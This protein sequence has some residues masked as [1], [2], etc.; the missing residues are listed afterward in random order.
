MS[1]H[2]PP[3]ADPRPRPRLCLFG[4]TFDPVHL[5]HLAIACAAK[6]ALA[7]DEVRFLPCRI[8]PHKLDRRSA[9]AVDR[10]TMLHL[11]T[12]GLPWAVVDPLELEQPGPSYSWQTATT[13]RTQHPQARLFWLVGGD[14]WRE[15]PTWARPDLLAATLE[16]IVVARDGVIE[17]RPGW[18]SHALPATHPASASAIRASAAAG[19]LRTDWLD[20]AVADYLAEHQLYCADQGS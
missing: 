11:A 12:R 5:G 10:V 20:P 4:G 15:L 6:S 3:A 7:L 19:T 8:S 17:P 16:F 1:N 9:S 2:P 13:F 18:I 14:Q